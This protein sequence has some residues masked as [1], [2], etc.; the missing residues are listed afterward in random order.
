MVKKT[1]RNFDGVDDTDTITIKAMV[2]FMYFLSLGN[3]DEAFKP[4]KM[5]KSNIVWG[6]MARMAVKS[7]RLDIAALCLG[8]MGNV[9]ALQAL[10]ESVQEPEIEA[11]AAVVALHLGMV[12]EAKELYMQAGRFDLLN[13]LY[14]A[15]IR[16]YLHLELMLMLT[17]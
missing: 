5:I 9:R 16:D 13:K 8:N 1:M 2:D 6:N 7:K 10:R 11:R 3:L 15:S 17:C 4:L 14:Q 12:D